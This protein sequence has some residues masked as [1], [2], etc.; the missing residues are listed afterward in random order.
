MN[1]LPDPRGYLIAP[2]LVPS[3]HVLFTPVWSALRGQPELAVLAMA[4]QSIAWFWLMAV[5]LATISPALWI[6]RK[7]IA[8]FPYK[9][10][11]RRDKLLL[12]IVSSALASLFLMGPFPNIHST[13]VSWLF[14]YF[15]SACFLSGIYTKHSTTCHQ[16]V[17]GLQP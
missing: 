17:A 11:S 15:A 4:W 12:G 13:P 10:V 2:I 5:S 3:L 16:E 6:A 8:A 7:Q 9:A 1:P 14:A